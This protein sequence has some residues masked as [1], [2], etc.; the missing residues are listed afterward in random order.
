[1][2]TAAYMTADL[3][4][5]DPPECEFALEAPTTRRLQTIIHY[6]SDAEQAARN[7]SGGRDPRPRLVLTDRTYEGEHHVTNALEF[8]APGQMS[9][10]CEL[11]HF[12]VLWS[13]HGL[14]LGTWARYREEVERAHDYIRE[15]GWT[16][17]EREQALMKALEDYQP[18]RNVA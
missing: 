4:V 6:P 7:W 3:R 8:W 17:D 9:Q 15:L 14:R 12:E 5:E 1:M 2:E 18:V 10:D 13:D 11:G 16:L